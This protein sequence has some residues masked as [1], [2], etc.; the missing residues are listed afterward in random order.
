[1]ASTTS[2]N[3]VQI[4]QTSDMCLLP[5]YQQGTESLSE[6]DIH[7]LRK[8]T[9]CPP[10]R[11]TQSV[12]QLVSKK[13]I[14][15]PNAP[16]V[17]AW[18][19]SFTYAELERYSNTV[20]RQL[21]SRT[22]HKFIPMLLGKTRWAA[23]AMLGILKAG[24]AFVLLDPSYPASRLNQI[25][26]SL[27]A[28]L[29][30]SSERTIEL[31]T[32]LDI[33][34][35]YLIDS[36]HVGNNS[37][38]QVSNL[39][40][41]TIHPN[42]P[43]YVAFTSGSTGVPKGAIITNGA[44]AT[45]MAGMQEVLGL[46]SHSRVLQFAAHAFDMSIFDYL[47]T[48]CAGGCICI[49]SDTE[50]KNDLAVTIRNKEVNWTCLTPSVARTLAGEELGGLEVLVLVGE[51][52]GRTDVETWAEKVNLK[53]LYGQ[54]ECGI[55]TTV[56]PSMNLMSDPT[57]IGYPTL[58]SCWV[59]NPDDSSQLL[60]V[61]TTGELLVEGPGLSEG[62]FNNKEGTVT[63]FI[64]PPGWIHTFRQL[65]QIPNRLY[66]TGDLVRYNSDG[67]L[68]YQG[69]KD[70]QVKVRGQRVELSEIESWLRRTWPTEVRDAVAGLIK[71]SE[72]SRSSGLVAFIAEQ[73]NASSSASGDD[74]FLP[75]SK[76]F[77]ACSQHAASK[78]KQLLPTYMIPTFYIPV[79]F[80]PMTGSGKTDRRKLLDKLNQLNDDEMDAYRGLNMNE[81]KSQP[82]SKIETELQELVAEALNVRLTSI[83]MEDNFFSIGG[84]SV[85]AIKLSAK[86]RQK[87]LRLFVEDVF[88]YPSIREM[89]VYISSNSELSS[90]ES[91]VAP[92]ALIDNKRE[93][94]IEA[95]ISQCKVNE[96]QIED[97]YPVTD[98]QQWLIAMSADGVDNYTSIWE[99]DFPIDLD[100][101]K[102]KNAWSQV[103]QAQSALRTRVILDSDGN[104]LQVV[105]RDSVQI[106]DVTPEEYSTSGQIKDV[107]GY[108]QPL[109]QVHLV[110]NLNGLHRCIVAA[111]HV[112]W[113]G[114]SFPLIFSQVDAAYHGHQPPVRSFQK[115]IA[116]IIKSRPKLH[117]LWKARLPESDEGFFPP[118]PYEGYKPLQTAH[119]E[120]TLPLSGAGGGNNSIT[121][122]TK[123]QL[124]LA[125][126]ISQHMKC[127]DTTF[128]LI[129]TGRGLPIDGID[130]MIGPTLGQLPVQIKWKVNERIEE[131]LQRAQIQAASMLPFETCGSRSL[132]KPTANKAAAGRF[133][134]LL[135]I[136]PVSRDEDSMPAMFNHG[137]DLSAKANV[138]DQPFAILCS[139]SP[140][141]V[142]VRAQYD[143]K[144][145]S[146]EQVEGFVEAF[147]S[148]FELVHHHPDDLMKMASG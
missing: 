91:Q 42:D 136:H 39:T 137:R 106:H 18:D 55:A 32:A 10:P 90:E 130:D 6:K 131:V 84:D 104:F 50:L 66:K 38:N 26:E 74:F 121:I 17:D 19:G 16:A 101:S 92:F 138:A 1:M 70:S 146:D 85:M 67:S 144:I 109:F 64:E 65:D 57:V 86:A 112:L 33:E 105:L 56:N 95:A 124:C 148:A 83:G 45:S 3:T 145:L 2:L 68:D 123:L 53:I 23:V 59:V 79:A 61:G 118:L 128:C 102:L 133:R 98:L 89:S 129:G 37:T 9:E 93:K 29:V 117:D 44:F 126:V 100:I 54:T 87:G 141:S 48:L 30:I 24:K 40:E 27:D 147:G 111:H 88:S 97:I 114:Y 63:S 80:I 82:N 21:I 143:S 60:P 76:D 4:H 139:M 94:A 49:P 134:T 103:I 107:W 75:P 140:S 58:T 119:K 8:W 7:T 81:I 5:S 31:T 115:V 11:E 35:V 12:H 41:W 47:L 22:S 36:I 62:Y 113:D 46:D 73:S 108:G 142:T 96:Q 71:P 14:N 120:C 34:D 99:F 43:A 125:M 52:V 78:L 51:A 15:Q 122:P 13:V 77:L 132:M 25:C 127:P 72:S 69:R 28:K 110:E 135:V 116:H 20:G